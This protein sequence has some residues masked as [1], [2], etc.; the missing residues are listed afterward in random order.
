M[1]ARIT[2]MRGADLTVFDFDYDLTWM[3]F[4]MNA[5]QHI[6]GRFGGRDEEDAEK[7]LSLKGLK[8]AMK[9]ALEAYSARPDAELK[10]VEKPFA[11]VELYPAARRVKKGQCIHC[12]QVHDF[13]REWLVQKKNWTPD[14]IWKYPP[15]ENI[16]LRLSPEQ[17]DVIE[18]IL[19]DSSASMADLQK[20]DVLDSINGASISSYGDLQY[21]LHQTPENGSLKVIY[22]RSGKK[23]EAT[24]SL[25]PG[26]RKSD[27]SWRG[28]MWGLEPK[29]HVYGR[30]LTAAQKKNLG[31]SP[32]RLA[33]R[34]GNFVPPRARQAGIRGGD[35]IIG[36]NGKELEMKMLQFNVWV[37]LNFEQGDR[38]V[39]NVIRNGRRK[40][41]PLVLQSRMPKKR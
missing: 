18:A 20:G 41:I 17:G 28:S 5:N 13:H 16:G 9:Q 38:I 36:A 3:G 22:T 6:Y 23:G 37:R 14:D 35:I 39:Y 33:F 31:L 21:L 2:N 25:K 12:H 4:F 7:S 26:W 27:F 19:S 40:D 15:P 30:D 11:R 1:L 10:R 8:Y 24:L 34:Q 32:Q 29:A